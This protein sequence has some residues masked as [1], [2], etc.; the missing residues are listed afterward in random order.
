MFL[1][2]NLTNITTIKCTGSHFSADLKRKWS[3][4]A[5]RQYQN[6]IL[7]LLNIDEYIVST[8]SCFN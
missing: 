3:A 8:A 2:S 7:V 5:H 1:Y 6:N 4:A